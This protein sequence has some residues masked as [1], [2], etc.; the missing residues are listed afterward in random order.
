MDIQGSFLLGAPHLD[1]PSGTVRMDIREDEFTSWE[2]FLWLWVAGASAEE[3]NAINTTMEDSYAISTVRLLQLA[4]RRATNGNAGPLELTR[5]NYASI[6]NSTQP[7]W[8]STRVQDQDPYIWSSVTNAFN[9]WDADYARVF[10][11][12]GI[13]TNETG[14]YKGMGALIVGRDKYGWGALISGQS[15][16][17]RGGFG[18]YEPW[19]D[20][21]DD[22]LNYDLVTSADGDWAFH[23]QDP[24]GNPADDVSVFD[25]WSVLDLDSSS[26]GHLTP[27][28][29]ASASQAQSLF[30]ST[31][32]ISSLRWSSDWGNPG[33]PSYWDTFFTTA[34]DPVNVISGEF[35]ID[36]ADLTL[37]GP[38]P[39]QI[40][41]N[42]QSKNLSDE[43]NLGYGWKISF[44]PYLTAVTNTNNVVLVYS[45]EPDGSTIA[46]RK[47]TNDVY[48]A[49][50][51]DNP[52]LNNDSVAGI[53]SVGNWFSASI[54][55]YTNNG[56]IF[57]ALHAPD[58]G[59]R[60]YRQRSDFAVTNGTSVLNRVRPY[61]DTWQD[62]RGNT[63]TFTFGTNSLADDYGQVNRVQ[64]SNG[65]FLGFN[66]DSYGRVVEAYTGDG[67][68]VVYEYD[69]FGDLTTVT[70]PDQAQFTYEYQHLWFNVTNGAAIT[71]NLDSNHLLVKEYKPEGR[72]LQNVYDSQRRVIAQLSTVGVDMN[73]YTNA[74]FTYNH[75][76]DDTNN[77]YSSTLTGQTQIRDILGNTTTYQYAGSL[78]TSIA[79]PLTATIKQDWWPTNATA[80][81]FPRSL[82]RTI[83]KRG[84]V[85]N[86]QYDNRGNVTNTVIYATNTVSGLV[87]DLTGDGATS[88]TNQ[89]T[90]TTNN[91]PLLTVDALGNQGQ[92]VYS[93]SDPWLPAQIIRCAGATP[94]STNFFIYTN[95]TNTVNDGVHSFTNRAYGL[96]QRAVRGGVRHQRLDV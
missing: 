49:Q 65:D 48:L 34:S 14:A 90:Y 1:E 78:I 80:P 20:F 38:L 28:A 21:G 54:V 69:R 81:G 68:R 53:G 30:S 6:G 79:D 8:G 67:R 22:F 55:R 4:Q 18:D 73:L 42:Y 24:S 44:V 62:H 43:N 61:L 85:T 94:V 52:M 31:D 40:R 63:L 93:T 77:T 64:S 13:V 86:Y 11:T 19:F 87:A 70:L 16:P 35:Y 46:Y 83:D 91:L 41:R 96:L 25:P 57:Y 39:L 5:L 58:G 17:L 66:Y 51:Q 2:N 9:A 74:V 32:P 59:L 10:L 12:P 37:P 33:P 95:A 82:Q 36:T 29:W 72:T 60:T 92:Y 23:Y 84:L 75:Q 89:A 71:T 76:Y 45:A 3:H 47:Q 15:T 27:G 88:L 26:S 7:G 56:T 50:P